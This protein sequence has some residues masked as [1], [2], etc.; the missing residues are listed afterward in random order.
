MMYK[1][2]RYILKITISLKKA[3]VL[4]SSSITNITEQKIL[5]C[6]LISLRAIKR[7]RHTFPMEKPFNFEID[8]LTNLWL[9]PAKKVC[10]TNEA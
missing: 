4:V 1:M 3:S 6:P 9:E 2:L 8:E 5:Y 10:H 7:S